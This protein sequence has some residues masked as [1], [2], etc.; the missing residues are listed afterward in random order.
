MDSSEVAIAEDTA[1]AYSGYAPITVRLVEKA[2]KPP[3]QGW[4]SLEESL[5]VRECSKCL[6]C[7]CLLSSVAIPAMLLSRT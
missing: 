1:Y 7:I 3:T 4:M 6:P 5:K 2:V